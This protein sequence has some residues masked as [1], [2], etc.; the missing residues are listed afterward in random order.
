M[1]M[2]FPVVDIRSICLGCFTSVVA[3]LIVRLSVCL[4]A[5]ANQRGPTP[6]KKNKDGTLATIRTMIIWG[7]GGHTA[8]MI[9]LIEKLSNKK[10][11]PVHC[12]LAETD[13]TSFEKIENAQVT[14]QF[15]HK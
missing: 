10:L 2:T 11:S 5:F 8:E 14:M 7:S 1:T 9:L 13:K 6:R 3:F 15:H 4:P 12:V